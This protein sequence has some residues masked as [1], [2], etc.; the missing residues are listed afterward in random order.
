MTTFHHQDSICVNYCR[1]SVSY[2]QDGTVLEA[3][4]ELLLDEVVRLQVDVGCGLI[5]HEYLCLSN[6]GPG[7]TEQL[8][9]P[10]REDVVVLS[11]LCLEPICTIVL[12]VVEQLDFFEGFLDFS[13]IKFF[14]RVKVLP[15]GALN[16]ERRLG[17]VSN[18]CP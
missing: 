2:N 5:K 10:D 12:Y 7:Q 6:D 17:N 4:L 3:A 14:E 15:D 9:L 18:A 16:Q 1:Q 8:L 13:I 11:N